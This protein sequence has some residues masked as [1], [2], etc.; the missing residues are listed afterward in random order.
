MNVLALTLLISLV[1]AG[2]FLVCFTFELLKPRK[3]SLEHVSLLP[4]EDDQLS[5]SLNNEL[6]NQDSK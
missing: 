1:L 6:P 5:N 4:L 3:T 2:I